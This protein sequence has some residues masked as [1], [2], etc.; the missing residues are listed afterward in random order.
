MQINAVR[1][2]PTDPAQVPT[3]HRWSVADFYRMAETGLIRERDR[4]ELIEGELIDMAPIGSR[5]AY[6]VDRLV[7]LIYA[8]RAQC[9]LPF[10]LRCQGPVRLST[11]SEPLPDI[12]LIRPGNYSTAH[13]GPNDVLLIIEVADST[14]KYDR[15]VKLALYARHDIPEVWLIDLQQDL[16]TQYRDPTPQGYRRSCVAAAS[17]VVEPAALPGL[18]VKLSELFA[19]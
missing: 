17:D 18:C 5:H 16:L 7:E 11:W 2:T 9:M 12:A 3:L 14:L 8:A 1:D 6:Q 4:M 15:D 10:M 19:G 13:P